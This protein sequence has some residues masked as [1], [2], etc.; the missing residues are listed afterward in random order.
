MAAL[1]CEICG[2]KLMAKAGGV[3]ECE[4]CG[5]TFE[6]ER[7]IQMVHE[8][9]GTVKVEKTL[10][11]EQNINQNINV[12][13]SVKMEGAASAENFIKRG[14][15]ALSDRKW[16]DA[17]RFFDQALNLDAENAE[18]YLGKYLAQRKIMSRRGLEYS[19]ERNFYRTTSPGFSNQVRRI[20]KYAKGELA[21]W[22]KTNDEKIQSQKAALEKQIAD[23]A[24]A[25]VPVRERHDKVKNLIAVG[26]RHIVGVKS[27]G[28]VLAVGNNDQG[29]CN[30]ENWTDIIAVA[31][32]GNR[33]VGL[34]AD[35]TVVA[36]GENQHGECNVGDWSDIVA[37]A[38][39]YAHTAGLKR[40][41]T[42]VAAGRNESDC[43][44]VSGWNNIVGIACGDCHTAGLR[45]DGSVVI[46]G[47]GYALQEGDYV[48][49]SA[50]GKYTYGVRRDGSDPRNGFTGVVD[51]LHE[52]WFVLKHDGTVSISHSE[53]H[54]QELHTVFF[55][56]KDIV[57]IAGAK[58]FG[59]IFVGL[60]SD[61]TVLAV[62]DMDSYGDPRGW[63]LFTDI[64]TFDEECQR[65]RPLAR[66][67]KLQE[68]NAQRRTQLREEQIRV[69]T[70]LKCLRGLFA[71]KRRKE[72]EAR[73][74]EI[75]TELKGLS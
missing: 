55:G 60:K 59:S 69:S 62:G 7:V 54:W 75:E 38:V 18:A 49:I 1:Q 44:N 43:C 29:Q 27:D 16:E 41:G 53:P 45:S 5:M 57:A 74:A 31:A 63:R 33:T 4:Y 39:G 25:L 22:I 32:R 56:W 65:E 50:Y 73:L 19:Y 15:L 13:G 47:D 70:E 42:V 37:I 12:S 66:K 28:T 30:V 17:D 3:F 20:R 6:K 48:S 8:V 10:R 61:G 11:L 26:Y 34:K 68:M 40:D 52:P 71:G 58:L 35:G 21:Q 36:T 9:K 24:V 2:G 72:L 51:T 46:Q 14:N 23:D 67:R 64:E